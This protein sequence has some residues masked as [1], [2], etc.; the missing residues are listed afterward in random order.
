MSEKSSTFALRMK[1]VYYIPTIEIIR[2]Q[3]EVVMDG[4]GSLSGSGTHGQS[5]AP[6]RRKTDVF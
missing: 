4:W 1:K 6:K 3:P 5:Q 2:L